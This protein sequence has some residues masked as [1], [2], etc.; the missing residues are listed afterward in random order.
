MRLWPLLPWGVLVL[1]TFSGRF[2]KLPLSSVTGSLEEACTPPSGPGPGDE[3]AQDSSYFNDMTPP[4]GL[5]PRRGFASEVSVL[6]QCPQHEGGDS[7][8]LGNRA[9][10]EVKPCDTVTH[11]SPK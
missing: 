1:V 2:P 7:T 10:R 11:F 9:G 8:A 3:G 4:A 6:L 5:V